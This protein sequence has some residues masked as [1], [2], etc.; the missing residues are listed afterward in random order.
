MPKD[1]HTGATDV[2]RSIASLEKCV[3]DAEVRAKAHSE[4]GQRGSML[5]VQRL[6]LELEQTLAVLRRR[7]RPE[8]VR[9]HREEWEQAG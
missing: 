1:R 3:V 7:S 9:A 5:A 4:A 8:H 2:D 6:I